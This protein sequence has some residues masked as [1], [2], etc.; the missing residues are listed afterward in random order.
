MGV[1]MTCTT[2][3][4]EGLHKKFYMHTVAHRA[5]L[6]KGYF[7]LGVAL[8]RVTQPSSF[9]KRFSPPI[10]KISDSSPFVFCQLPVR[11]PLTLHRRTS[12][13]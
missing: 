8:E 9:W 7:S 1:N 6:A 13:L 11:Q 2:Y 3:T 4:K 5:R 10:T 12:P